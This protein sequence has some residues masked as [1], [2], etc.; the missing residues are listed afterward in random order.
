MVFAHKMEIQKSVFFR[1][2]LQVNEQ[3]VQNSHFLTIL[4]GHSTWFLSFWTPFLRFRGQKGQKRTFFRKIVSVRGIMK[5]KIH[6]S[7]FCHFFQKSLFWRFCRQ[8]SQKSII[9]SCYFRFCRQKISILR[10]LKN[11][12]YVFLQL[13]RVFGTSEDPKKTYFYTF[14]PWNINQM[15]IKKKI[16]K[17]VKNHV[18]SIFHVPSSY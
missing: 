18:F 13:S 3:S 14:C 2:F 1:F 8:N 4:I 16:F 9:F 10:I 15:T 7:L 11:K 17:N 5:N 6:F 12:K